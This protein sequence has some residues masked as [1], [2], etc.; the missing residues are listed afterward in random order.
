MIADQKRWTTVN[1]KAD[2]P[3][4]RRVEDPP[5]VGAVEE[6]EKSVGSSSAVA[7]RVKPRGRGW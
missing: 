2:P 1:E 7:S 4:M 6:K 3:L 5:L